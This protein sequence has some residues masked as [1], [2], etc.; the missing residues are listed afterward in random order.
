[1]QSMSM[2]RFAPCACLLAALGACSDSSPAV[3][4]TPS[5]PGLIAP[6]SEPAVRE[7]LESWSAAV[8][9]TYDTVVTDARLA[10]W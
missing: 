10:S 3:P 4:T 6:A 8:G 2:L 5:P 9:I 1:M 7:A